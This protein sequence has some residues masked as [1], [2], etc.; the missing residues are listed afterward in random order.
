M[1]AEQRAEYRHNNE[2]EEAAGKDRGNQSVARALA[3]LDLLAQVGDDLGV[4]D[5]A[6]RLG[7]ATSIVQRL[8]TSLARYGYVEQ[9][10]SS[11]KYRVGYQAF[12]VG[13]GYVLRGDVAG[14]SQRD[15]R[16]LTADH[17]LTSYAGVMRGG[18]TTYLTGL[19]ALG[20][21]TFASA[22]G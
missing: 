8:I 22:P 17:R 16:G 18:A 1:E 3:I 10:P 6:R 9:S 12:R 14:H 11:L 15:L 20:P 4:R 5:I 2:S 7:L 19:Q 21:I 13:N